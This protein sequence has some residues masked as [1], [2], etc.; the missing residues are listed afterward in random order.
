MADGVETVSVLLFDIR[1]IN[2][3]E[4][5]IPAPCF[6]ENFEIPINI[7]RVASENGRRVDPATT[8]GKQL[9]L[10]DT[11]DFTAKFH[12]PY[13]EYLYSYM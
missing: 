2:I 6:Q 3:Y 11:A 5:T 10:H 4:L 1:F 13:L 12:A 9:L 7:C 8:K